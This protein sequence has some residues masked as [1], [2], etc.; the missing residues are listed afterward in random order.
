MQTKKEAKERFAVVLFFAWAVLCLA[1]GSI[2]MVKH[3]IPL[4]VAFIPSQSFLSSVANSNE[5]LNVVHVLTE[6]CKCSA[7]ISRYLV[8]RGPLSGVRE[9]VLY[10][11]K[12]DAAIEPFREA[13]FETELLRSE[14][15][16]A[17]YGITASPMFVVVNGAGEQLYT[18]GY[19]ERLLRHS[20]QV[21]DRQ[22][23][24]GLAKGDS[25]SALPVF[26]CA[27]S[28]K[29]KKMVDPIGII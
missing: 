25:F 11:A 21:K 7:V 15:Q 26:G 4:P 16:I 20:G 3:I 14:G 2:L 9:R 22:I 27:V 1:L 29:L 8:E 28:K 10:A 13:G 18:G 5:P 24:A 12:S 6:G 23:I 19:S 17:S